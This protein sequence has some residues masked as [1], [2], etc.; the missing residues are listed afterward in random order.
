MVGLG[1]MTPA[2][3]NKPIASKHVREK[4]PEVLD[5]PLFIYP[6]A[7]SQV[8]APKWDDYLEMRNLLTEGKCLPF[9]ECRIAIPGIVRLWLKYADGMIHILACRYKNPLAMSGF[10]TDLHKIYTK[11]S[12]CG[13][14]VVDF[15]G[16]MELAQ[17]NLRVIVHFCMDS[18][19]SGNFIAEV[20]PKPPS[21]KPNHVKWAQS[22]KHYVI[23]HR[24]DRMN[25]VGAVP[26]PD[27]KK[28]TE[29]RMAHTRRAHMRI[30]R[31]ARFKEK[32]GQRVFVKSC[33]VGPAEWK[34]NN[35]IYK[36]LP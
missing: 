26:S 18:M 13:I 10:M 28:T 20:T 14:D 34:I 9:P 3:F 4:C 27:G 23:V 8:K 11:K 1:E 21:D 31:S 22:Q 32:Q 35:S 29:I 12:V 16:A 5:A 15:E 6:D 30:L 19:L 25:S 2:E 24:K 17:V 7:G 33:W 36:I